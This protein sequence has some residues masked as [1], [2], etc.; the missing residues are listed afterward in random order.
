MD[1]RQRLIAR[2]RQGYRL[3][4]GT[5]PTRFFAAPGRVNLI[6]EHVDYNDGYVL[7]C[8]IDRETIV[9]LGPPP[10]G[11]K[12][13]RFEAV[14]LDMGD[15]AS[16]RD[17]FDL[18]SA[19]PKGENNWQNHVRGVVQAMGR[20]GH[21]VRPARIAI[22]G[23]VPIGAGLSSSAAFGVAVAL[24]VSEYSGIGLASE[25]L[26]KIAQIA[27][28]D[29][30]GTACGIM[31]Q[32]ASA[33][34]VADNALLLDCRSLQHLPIPIHAS[35]AIT[36]IDTGLRRD[37]TTSAFNQRRAECEAVAQ[38]F[39]V[40][41]L[42]DLEADRL[43]AEEAKLDPV[44][45]QRARH[46]VTEME[47]VEPVAV[48]LATGDTAALAG[49]MDEAHRSLSADFDVSLPAIDRLFELV[50]DTLGEAGGVRLTGAGFGGCLVAVT[51]RD[52]RTLIDDAVA[53]NNR[54]TT[55][56][57][58]SAETYRPIGGAAPI[59]LG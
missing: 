52:A 8:A 22:A 38:H 33:A 10:S 19:I 3:A 11:D 54:A 32:M 43:F 53:R 25:M 47:R 59:V 42:R 16:A 1:R 29:F 24:A 49:L 46:V 2:A 17:G 26:A 14:A 28:N 20:Y 34:A 15:M 36:V 27:E 50:R 57:P 45:F 55:G 39:G 18:S 12:V 37:L 31:D 5:E 7:P 58:A 23:D 30:V 4:Y 9:A 35:L 21:R 48:A 51:R 56:L 6:G 40:K 44:L 13:P 41:G